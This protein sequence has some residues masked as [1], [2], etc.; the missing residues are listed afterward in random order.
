MFNRTSQAQT[1][2]CFAFKEPDTW[3]KADEFA[4]LQHP[5]WGLFEIR[6]WKDLHA[7]QLVD[8]WFDVV[9]VQAHLKKGE[10]PAPLWLAWQ[11]PPT[12]P[13]GIQVSAETT[14]QTYQHRWPIE[15]SIRFRPGQ[16]LRQATAMVDIAPIS[17][18]GIC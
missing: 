15:S 12:M 9:Q 11:A 16:D 18:G 10:P 14:W 7:W 8:T 17:T 3:G 13:N 6:R 5:C 4:G 2:A 1:K